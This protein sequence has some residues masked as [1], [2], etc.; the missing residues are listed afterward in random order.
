MENI[1]EDNDNEHNPSEDADHTAD[2]AFSIDEPT[3]GEEIDDTQDAIPPASDP[4]SI[5]PPSGPYAVEDRLT[6]DPHATFGG[7]LSGIA[8]RYGWDVAITRIAFL[9]GVVATG[10]GLAVV[11]LLSWLIV[12]R[13]QYWPPMVRHRSQI[14]GRDIGIALIVL[15]TLIA[16]GI[17]SGNAAAI[18]VPLALIGAGIWMLV[19]NPREVAAPAVAFSGMPQAAPGAPT[20]GGFSQMPSVAPQPAPRRSRASRT[21]IF[22]VIAAVLLIPAL[23]I[24]A[25]IFV[26][27]A[28][29]DGEFDFG[30]EGSIELIYSDISQIP[31]DINE[32]GRV[33]V[34]LTDVDFSSI[35]TPDERIELDLNIEFGDLTVKLPEDV[36]VDVNA[37]SFLGGDLT[38]FDQTAEGFAPELDFSDDDPQLTL[39]IEV[40]AGR[41]EVVRGDFGE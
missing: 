2:S 30:D 24:G 16:L 8:N 19:Q 28:V 33:V 5:P 36:R 15:A 17:G 7:V 29:G 37:D 14:S 40:D 31:T 3:A 10:G 38:V 41:L 1:N 23:I 18:L 26:V 21:I 34:D 6:R 12:P 11:Y 20:S 25:L 32:S 4:G 27:T 13:A 9:V 22:G 35:D 39:D